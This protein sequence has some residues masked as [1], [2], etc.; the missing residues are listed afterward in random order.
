MI[1]IG[2]HVIIF[3]LY[4]HIFS[5][6]NGDFASA[7]VLISFGAVL[8]VLNPVQLIVMAFLEVVFYSMN[9]YILI[10]LFEVKQLISIYLIINNRPTLKYDKPHEKRNNDT[11]KLLLDI[12][13][14]RMV[15]AY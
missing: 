1:E 9:E 7:A 4:Y 8:G 6:L 3:D 13:S 2:F 12:K 11:V 15:L 5:I 14:N 10:E